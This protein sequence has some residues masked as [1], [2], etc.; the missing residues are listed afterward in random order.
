M[1]SA[2]QLKGLPEIDPAEIIALMNDPNDLEVRRHLPLASGH[3]GPTEYEQFVKR[4][5]KMW[6]QH[7]FGPWAFVQNEEFIGWGGLQPE[8][9]D[10]DIGLI[11]HPQSWGV[12]RHL[13]ETIV[14]F[15]FQDFGLDS[16]I[17][18]LPPTRS[19]GSGLQR[20]GVEPDGE[21]LIAGERFVRFRLHRRVLQQHG[22]AGRSTV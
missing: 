20:L 14:S 7:G 15:A 21:A 22:S 6:H 17:A 1:R 5:E 18:M 3:F 9:K 4:K 11:L 10:A 8:G 13:D 12:G 19:R 2:I 16:A